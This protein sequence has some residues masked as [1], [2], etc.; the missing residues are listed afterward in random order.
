MSKLVT[1]VAQQ[2]GNGKV[3]ESAPDM[4]YDSLIEW[5]EAVCACDGIARSTVP[6]TVIYE[7]VLKQGDKISLATIRKIVKA[8]REHHTEWDRHVVFGT[9]DV[10]SICPYDG[11]AE[12][13][14]FVLGYKYPYLTARELCRRIHKHFT[15]PTISL[16]EVRKI[17]KEAMKARKES[18]RAG[19]FKVSKVARADYFGS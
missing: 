7:S 5:Y 17:R 6:A 10:H 8:Q 11:L 13:W 1:K 19:L 2:K 15:R 9:P 18:E 4:D 12:S 3:I 14:A 16:D